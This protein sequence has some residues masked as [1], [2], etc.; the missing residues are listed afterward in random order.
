MSVI[1]SVD[2]TVNHMRFKIHPESFHVPCAIFNHKY[3]S[4]LVLEPR[5]EVKISGIF[6]KC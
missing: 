6:V 5:G 1:V 3:C 4:T 2:L